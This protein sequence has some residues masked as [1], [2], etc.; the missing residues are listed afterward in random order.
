[1]APTLNSTVTSI[2]HSA[3]VTKYLE[4]K[5]AEWHVTR[6]IAAHR[7]LVLSCT[8]FPPEDYDLLAKLSIL[9]SGPNSFELT[10]R[11]WRTRLERMRDDGDVS[12]DPQEA[13]RLIMTREYHELLDE[14]QRAHPVILDAE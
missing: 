2:R 7:L 4:E 14:L 5:A 13:D 11:E 1:M 10:C 3:G 8:A 9:G 6:G 12:T